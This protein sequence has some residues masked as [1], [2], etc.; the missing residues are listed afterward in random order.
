[1]RRFTLRFRSYGAGAVFLRLELE[2]LTLTEPFF[3]PA[4]AELA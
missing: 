2:G 3:N 4:A 1:M